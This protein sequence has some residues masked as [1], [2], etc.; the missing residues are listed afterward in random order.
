MAEFITKEILELSKIYNFDSQKIFELFDICDLSILDLSQIHDLRLRGIIY[1]LLCL[2]PKNLIESKIF[3]NILVIVEN[4]KDR[5]EKNYL[6]EKK[7]VSKIKGLSKIFDPNDEFND[8]NK[9]I[10]YIIAR[11]LFFIQDPDVEYEDNRE[12]ELSILLNQV[13]TDVFL[14]CNTLQIILK[15]REIINENHLKSYAL[16][17]LKS[18]S[19]HDEKVNFRLINTPNKST[20]FIKSEYKTKLFV[21]FYSRALLTPPNFIEDGNL[22]LNGGFH[23]LNKRKVIEPNSFNNDIKIKKNIW[24]FVEIQNNLG[25][26]IDKDSV[27]IQKSDV[28][29]Q[30]KKDRTIIKEWGELISEIE[31]LN[32]GEL[33]SILKMEKHK[34][35]LKK[36]YYL[37]DIDNVEELKRVNKK[38]RD[39]SKFSKKL[40]NKKVFLE[41]QINKNKL[42]YSPEIQNKWLQR[43]FSYAFIIKIYL[44]FIEF[45]HCYE[46]PLYFTI[47]FDFRGRYY[48]N[49]I[50]A[51]SSGWPF[52]FLY[53]FGKIIPNEVIV[54]SK[55]ISN[56][57]LYQEILNDLCA[58]LGDLSDAQKNAALWILK[59]VGSLTLEKKE[60]TTE[61]EFIKEGYENFIKR[62]KL[63]NLLENSELQYY[64]LILDQLK[65]EMWDRYIIKDVSGSIFQ[66]ASKILGIKNLDTLK[67]LNINNEVYHD[68]YFELIKKINE[69]VPEKL[70]SIFTRKTLKKTIMTKY[71]SATLY[72]SFKYFLKEAR[73]IEGFSLIEKNFDDIIKSFKNVYNLLKNLEKEVF[74]Q[75]STEDFKEFLKSRKIDYVEYDDFTFSIRC[76]K[77]DKTRIDLVVDGKR[78][79]CVNYKPS[80]IIFKKKTENAQIPNIFHG[81]DSNRARSLVKLYKKKCFTIHDAFG[82]SYLSVDKFVRDANRSFNINESRN[83]YMGKNKVEGRLFSP[84]IAI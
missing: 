22:G 53:N 21:H 15:K 27:K 29:S 83:F 18:L 65:V 81:E 31:D 60:I 11:R 8:F 14:Y 73:T 48:H 13:S 1:E 43:E 24:N 34:K 77:M 64:Y 62:T 52:R 20:Y 2:F 4:L 68:P 70:K 39:S 45:F 58:R 71:Y 25:F 80:T 28:E 74:F 47:Y 38:M 78:I 17:I 5:R 50:V 67:K 16:R 26:H 33:N 23:Y 41:K 57:N 37:K 3:E 42:K 76:F 7:V 61:K 49:S 44:E 46:D 6:V 54:N 19:N 56:L 63:K 55:T 12:I 51:P 66:N 32:E 36:N 75:N 30:L 59:S 10:S 69:V 82:I 9:K 40:E 79:T 84:F 72:S 35:A